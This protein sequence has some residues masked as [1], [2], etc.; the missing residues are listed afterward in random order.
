MFLPSIST[1]EGCEPAGVTLMGVGA[2][3][4]QYHLLALARAGKNTYMPTVFKKTV[5]KNSKIL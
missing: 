2:V 3:L 4:M 5:F 1:S